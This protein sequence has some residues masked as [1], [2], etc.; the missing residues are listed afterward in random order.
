MENML[1][2]NKCIEGTSIP[3][4]PIKKSPG[5]AALNRTGQQEESLDEFKLSERR[6]TLEGEPEGFDRQN[7]K[8][9][10]QA[11]KKEL[12]KAETAYGGYRETSKRST[13]ISAA[14]TLK[15]LAM[16]QTYGGQKS[17]LFLTPRKLQRQRKDLLK[18]N[19]CG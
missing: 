14:S 10:K 6:A 8:V 17:S 1:S 7:Y 16:G 13:P 3:R 4:K 15:S 12:R 5:R 19:N 11:A 18:Y 9:N 2:V